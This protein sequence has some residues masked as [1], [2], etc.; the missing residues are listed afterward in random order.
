MALLL[1]HPEQLGSVGA[2]RPAGHAQPDRRG[3][4]DRRRR[5]GARG[6][7]RLVWAAR[8]V[9]QPGQRVRGRRGP[10]ALHVVHR[11]P[12]QRRRRRRGHRLGGLPH[13]R[14]LHDPPRRPQPPVLEQ[15]HVQRPPGVVGVGR[16]GSAVGIGG[17]GQR[18][19]RHPRGA[20]RRGCHAGHAVAARGL[21]HHDGRPRGHHGPPGHG[22][23]AGRR[24]AGTHRLRR[25]APGL[26]EPCPRHRHRR[27]HRTAAT[28]PTCRAC[29]PP[30]CRGSASTTWP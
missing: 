18:R 24:H 25:P 30:R 6:S 21:P 22:D 11:R 23:G 8:G 14:P 17:A 4:G 10:A 16:V 1:R 29:R 27:G 3:Q 20:T 7:P 2:R 26:P 19:H 13:P 9:R 12:A 5:P 15:R 28:F